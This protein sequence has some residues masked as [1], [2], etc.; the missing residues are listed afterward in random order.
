MNPAET[1]KLKAGSILFERPEGQLIPVSDLLGSGIVE[2]ILQRVEDQRNEPRF[3]VS[4]L[5]VSG[6]IDQ[7]ELRLRIDLQIQVNTIKEWVTIPLTLGDVYLAGPPKA[8]TTAVDGQS[9]LTTGEQ[10]TQQWH[11]RGKGLHTVSMDLVGK[12]RVVSPGV[13][14]ISLNLPAARSPTRRFGS[15]VLWNC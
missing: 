11:L 7:G 2:E 6:D 3:T 15:A 8:V 13:T 1:Q 12:T 9:M 4:Q 14:Q 5:E 10:N